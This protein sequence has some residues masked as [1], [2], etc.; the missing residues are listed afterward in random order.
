MKASSLVATNAGHEMTRIS[1]RSLSFTRVAVLT[2]SGYQGLEKPRMAGS[3]GI[4]SNNTPVWVCFQRQITS[5]PTSLANPKVGS[6]C[7][8]W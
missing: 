1:T 8:N 2:A 6:R 4:K 7:S 5:L 3:V